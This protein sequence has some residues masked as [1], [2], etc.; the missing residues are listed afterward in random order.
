MHQR[1]IELYREHRRG[2]ISERSCE[3]PGARAEVDDAVATLDAGVGNE[4]GREPSAIE[5]V[6]PEAPSRR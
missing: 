2:A 1:S 5:K 3:Q 4:P 6:L